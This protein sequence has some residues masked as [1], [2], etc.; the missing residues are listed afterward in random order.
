MK[1]PSG[2]PLDPDPP[3]FDV[4]PLPAV[5]ALGA[6]PSSTTPSLGTSNLKARDIRVVGG[7]DNPANYSALNTSDPQPL[8][9]GKLPVD[10][11]FQNLPVPTTA[12]DPVNVKSTTYGGKSVIGLPLI[13][14]AITLQPGVYDWIEV[15]SGQAI[16]QPGVYLIRGV[17]PLTH[18]ALN[19]ARRRPSPGE[20]R[21]VLYHEYCELF[22]VQRLA[23]L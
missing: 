8:K 14:P 18:Q 16:F 13:G 3:A 12:V 10:D 19:V 4:S 1:C 15:I 20:R 7:I 6:L 21:D 2:R 22:A 5:P 17:N 9:S 23:R 11:P